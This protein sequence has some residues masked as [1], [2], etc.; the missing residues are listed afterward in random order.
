ML[1]LAEMI[2]AGTACYELYAVSCRLSL[3]EISVAAYVFFAFS[4]S[5]RVH[6]SLFLN[7]LPRL[8]FRR[9]EKKNK[10]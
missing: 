10:V 8:P 3:A 2:V 5:M 4:A 9:I 6:E 1:S 7:S